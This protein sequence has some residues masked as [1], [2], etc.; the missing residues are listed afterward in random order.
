[1]AL[2]RGEK[3]RDRSEAGCREGERE[4]GRGTKRTRNLGRRG[5]LQAEERRE[6]K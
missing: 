2:W 3:E 6:G 4:K 1:M 5:S